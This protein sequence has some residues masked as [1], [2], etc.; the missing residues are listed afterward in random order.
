MRHHNNHNS[1]MMWG[2]MMGCFLLAI[3]FIALPSGAG[4]FAIGSNWLWLIFVLLF[5]GLHV[6]MLFQ[7]NGQDGE[8]RHE[9]RPRDKREK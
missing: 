7:G 9:D 2:M 8:T 3:M 6:G 4:G 5:I 1:K